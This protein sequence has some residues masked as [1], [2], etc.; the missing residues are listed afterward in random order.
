M[1][2]YILVF[3]LSVVIASISQIILKTSANKTYESKL[4][5]YLNFRVIFA[6][7]LFFLSSLI[8]VLAYKKVPLSMGPMLEATGYVWVSVLGYIFL[9]EKIGKRKAAGL[10]VIIIGIVVAS[11]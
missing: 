6:Y 3:L 5:E 7:F 9:H 4:K 10:V 2:T 1:T 11:I 8:T